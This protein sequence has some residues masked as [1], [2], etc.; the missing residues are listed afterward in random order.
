M[1]EG[2]LR[3]IGRPDLGN[4]SKLLYDVLNGIVYEDDAQIVESHEKKWYA[5]NPRSVYK[6]T[7]I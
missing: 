5:E 4:C 2:K 1:L 7:P 3:P 6:I